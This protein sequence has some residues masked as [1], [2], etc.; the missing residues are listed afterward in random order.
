MSA[1][2]ARV[3]EPVPKAIRRKRWAIPVFPR[4][5]RRNGVWQGGK[6]AR[7]HTRWKKPEIVGKEA[8]VVRQVMLVIA[9][10]G[11]A[12]VGGAVV[13][14]PGFRWA[15][16]RLLLYMGL[17]DEGEIATIDLPT[18][19]DAAVAT[20]DEPTAKEPTVEKPTAKEPEVKPATAAAAASAES[21]RPALSR[22]APAPKAEPKAT[23]PFVASTDPKETPPP[24]G[25]GDGPTKTPEPAP[26]PL[27]PSVAPAALAEPAAPA[28]EPS[29]GDW[30]EIRGKLTAAGVSRY[31]IEGEPGGRVVFA[32]LIPLAGKQAVSQ[33]FEA[34][35]DDEFQAARAVLKRVNLWRATQA[36]PAK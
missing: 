5:S 7:L 12:F 9:V 13:N 27:D 23:E 16:E 31:T 17:Q 1:D 33:R 18:A 24:P 15:Q 3:V 11:A 20:T 2:N 29:G 8:E 30:A 26:A 6:H 21:P 22:E 35:G 19:P 28:A 34:E 10:V 4:L 32:C 25:A 36:E 14:G